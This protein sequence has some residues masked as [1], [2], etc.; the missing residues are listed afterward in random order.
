[1]CEKLVWPIRN[2]CEKKLGPLSRCL[3]DVKRYIL[4]DEPR[5]DQRITARYFVCEKSRKQ[6]KKHATISFLFSSWNWLA[7]ACKCMCC[8]GNWLCMLVPSLSGK[9][10][11]LLCILGIAF[12][13]LQVPRKPV[14]QVLLPSFLICGFC[15]F[16]DVMDWFKDLHRER[17]TTD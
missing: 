11:C 17:S 12:T 14:Q 4:G 15:R 8:H 3:E 13:V 2:V 1:M 6:T 7:G 16:P 5:S 9:R 10:V